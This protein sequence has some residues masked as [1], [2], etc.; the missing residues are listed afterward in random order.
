[1]LVQVGY[2]VHEYARNRWLLETIDVGHKTWNIKDVVCIYLTSRLS[3]EIMLPSKSLLATLGC[4]CWL[5]P[6]ALW[7]SMSQLSARVTQITHINQ[8]SVS[9]HLGK[10]SCLTEYSRFHPCHKLI[11]RQVYSLPS[12]TCASVRILAHSRAL[13]PSRSVTNYLIKF[14]CIKATFMNLA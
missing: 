7:H 8:R 2:M 6:P 5:R 4:R 3:R 14:H 13:S 1:M 9:L 10:K 12:C 11:Q